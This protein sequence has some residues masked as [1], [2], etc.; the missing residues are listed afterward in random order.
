[1]LTTNLRV[2]VVDQRYILKGNIVNLLY[3]GKLK[4][5]IIEE[6]KPDNESNVANAKVY[7]I[8]HET[9]LTIR[10]TTADNVQLFSNCVHIFGKKNIN[11]SFLTRY[12]K[13]IHHT[14]RM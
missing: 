8:T 4:S 7:Q 1:M 10:N 6:I 11:L 3:N 12:I 13:E 5:F 2:C 14:S 9:N